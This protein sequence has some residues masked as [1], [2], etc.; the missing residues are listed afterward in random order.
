[1]K[2]HDKNC[3]IQVQPLGGFDQPLTYVTDKKTISSLK[4]GSLVRI[5]LE[6]EK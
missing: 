1:M 6:K 5:P 4:L 2:V 3:Q